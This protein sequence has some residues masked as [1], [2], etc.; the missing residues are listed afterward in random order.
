MTRSFPSWL[1]FLA[2]AALPAVA[3]IGDDPREGP[4][5]PLAA[6][7]KMVPEPTL[8]AAEEKATFQLPPGFRI[9]LVAADPMVRDPVA[10]A[11]DWEGNLWVVEY[12]NFNSGIIQDLP[13]LDAGVKESQVP[14][15]RIVKLE[16]SRHD[17][18]YDRRIVWLEGLER[19]KGIAI[20]HD[21][22]LISDQPNLWLARDLHG[23]GHCDEKTLL[24][25]NYEAWDDPEE[26]GTL[27]W[28]RDNV[29][30]DIDFSYD[31]KYR[32]G[33]PLTPIAV[34]I[35]G[36][37]GISQDD[38]GRLYSDRNSD[39]LH[40]DL[41]APTYGV[42]NANVSE[43]PWAYARIAE[44]QEVWP[45]HRTPA[46][47]RAYR[48]GVL[49]EQT[50]GLRDD[51][52]LL[53]F[54]AACSP[55]VYRGTN[56]PARFYNNAFVCE[57]A[58]NLIKRDLLLEH[59]GDITAVNA[60]DRREFLT[61][62]DSRFRPVAL[63]NAP[64]GSMLVVDFYHGILQEYH[65]ITTYLRNQTLGRDLEGPMFGLGRL[66]KITYE[67]GPLD[68]AQPDFPHQSTAEMVKLLSKAN[69]WWRDSAQQELV[70]RGDLS[71]VPALSGLARTAP[72]EA[73]RVAALWTLDGLDAT[74][75]PL[76]N[77]ALGDPSPKVRAAAVRLHERW[78]GGP[79][80]DTAVAQLNRVLHDPEP[81]VSVQLALSLG[82]AHT[83]A[84]LD[85]LFQVLLAA[86]D[87]P[88]VP[89]AIAS[90]LSGRE[91]DFF[92]RLRGELRQLGERPEIASMVTIL[93]SAIVHQGD[94][95]QIRQVISEVSDAGGLPE[96]ARL[97]AIDGF[98]PLVRPPF[99][100]TIGLTRIT[101]SASFD[102]LAAS[103]D[104]QV[105]DRIVA[106]QSRLVRVEAEEK[107][108]AAS[109]RPLTAEE[110]VLYKEGQATFQL[111][112]ACHQQN[113]GGL[114][115]VAPSLVDSHWVPGYPEILVRIV[116]CG[117]EGTPGFPGAMPPIAGTFD[118][119]KIA[120][121]LTYIRNSWGLHAGGV[122]ISL[123]AQ[124]RAEVGNRQAAWNDAEL[125]RV[126]N[127][128]QR[129]YASQK[130]R[131]AH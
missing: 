13:A 58:A 32:F 2:C 63:L 107:A 104:G 14:P 118:N 108:R 121:V 9:E 102:P 67:G 46:I 101:K 7:R 15:C 12:S 125:R 76:L 100:R 92:Q 69:G 53:E 11:Y 131:R 93:S 77:D 56:F 73:T 82:E 20:V 116:L 80:A 106:L 57:P 48:R 1:A 110:E 41:F 24:M 70:E 44:D 74:T 75:L 50:G 122:P 43:Y 52:T 72:S 129:H 21:G 130:N 84:S 61:S 86:G 66:W 10:A 22:V 30:H 27:M 78:L 109:A 6:A 54:T 34:P 117:K 4:Q 124:V 81:E 23:T 33:K 123:V 96:W 59:E 103:S 64:D 79:E 99:R 105:H 68:A 18:H 19:P 114:A 31:Y 113:G 40:C 25:G 90:G 3:Q 112:A 42:R 36:Q 5:V 8:N 119:R 37:F 60:Y 62:T 128:L 98:Q 85:S 71:A 28:G 88:F 55:L 89:K 39:Q 35:R 115:H 16:S 95:E 120:G 94:K 45:S 97:A 83:A 87:H 51:G 49:G 38:W 111:C 91:F 127:D 65:Y 26:S 29:I 17:G 47:N 126:E